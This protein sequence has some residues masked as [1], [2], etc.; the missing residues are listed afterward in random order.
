MYAAASHAAWKDAFAIF[1]G[2]R[3]FVTE[4]DSAGRLD[5]EAGS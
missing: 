2:S 5:L 4:I 3:R 1:T